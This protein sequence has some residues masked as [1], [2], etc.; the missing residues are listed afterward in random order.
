MSDPHLL[1]SLYLH[2]DLPE[3][4]IVGLIRWLICKQILLT[5]ILLELRECTIKVP[6]SLRDEHAAACR[7][8]KPLEHAF[9]NTT[10]AGITDP[11]RV[12]HHF[13]SKRLVDSIADLLATGGIVA[14]RKQNDRLTP[15]FLRKQV[16]CGRDYGVVDRGSPLP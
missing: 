1:A 12:N 5:Q 3:A 4:A 14:I 15:G 10:K 13:G 11:D 6:H 16:A 9:V 7:I 2:F 8:T